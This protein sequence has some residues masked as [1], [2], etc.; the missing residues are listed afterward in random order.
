MRYTCCKQC[1]GYGAINSI[2]NKIQILQ[3]S[4]PIHINTDNTKYMNM[5]LTTWH[6]PS[7]KVG[8]N[9]A[10]MC[11][12]AGIVRSRMQATEFSFI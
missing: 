3:D 4:K 7:A 9:F 11:R 1:I 8:T 5:A 2:R 10:D 12:S 6:P